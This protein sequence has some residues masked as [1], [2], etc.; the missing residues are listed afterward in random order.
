MAPVMLDVRLEFEDA[1]DP[2][3]EESGKCPANCLIV[4]EVNS[5]RAK[6]L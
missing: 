3:S 1:V 2:T 4:D 6:I 5:V